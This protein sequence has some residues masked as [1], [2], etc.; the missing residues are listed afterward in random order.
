MISDFDIYGT[1][2]VLLVGAGASSVPTYDDAGLEPG[3]TID[4]PGLIRGAYL[5]CLLQAGWCLR[6]TR[7]LDLVIEAI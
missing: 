6:V 1:A 2:E 4:G 3:Q 5:T 7:N